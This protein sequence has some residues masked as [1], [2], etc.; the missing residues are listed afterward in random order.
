MKQSIVDK[1]I[2][3]IGITFVISMLFSCGNS[4]KELNDFLANKNLPIRVGE[5]IH[6]IHQDSGFVNYKMETPLL[7]DYEN[8]KEHPYYE[9][10]KG[11]TITS[12]RKGG[13]STKITGNYAISFQKT[14]VAEI[15]GNVVV[16]NYKENSILKTSQLYWDQKEDLFYSDKKFVLYRDKDTIIA[17]GFESKGD[18]SKLETRNN[19]GS[20]N[21]N[22]KE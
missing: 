17:T 21:L 13:D 20:F 7:Y 10:P 4:N 3:G 19:T 11:I 5:N 2:K 16:N 15:R 9:F 14:G 18:L 8:R 6:D 1:Y 22:N 12:Y